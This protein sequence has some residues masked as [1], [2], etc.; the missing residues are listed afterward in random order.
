MKNYFLQQQISLLLNANLEFLSGEIA[1]QLQ[2]DCLSQHC[3]VMLVFA[4]GAKNSAIF[5]SFD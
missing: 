1:N 5:D 4:T 2:I 3:Q